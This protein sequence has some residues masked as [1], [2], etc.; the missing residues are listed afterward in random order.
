MIQTITPISHKVFELIYVRWL[1]EKK[2]TYGTILFA[3]LII[4]DAILRWFEASF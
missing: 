3:V 1:F 2:M 4:V